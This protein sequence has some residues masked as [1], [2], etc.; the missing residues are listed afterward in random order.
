MQATVTAYDED[1]G[2]GIAVLD[3]GTPL[4]FTADAVGYSGLRRLRCGQRIAVVR[5]GGTITRL[6]IPGA[7]G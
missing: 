6:T 2:G 5:T 4:V 1:A 3:D 7:S